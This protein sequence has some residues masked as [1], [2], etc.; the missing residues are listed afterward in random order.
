[1]EEFKIKRYILMSVEG[2]EGEQFKSYA[3]RIDLFSKEKINQSTAVSLSFL[4]ID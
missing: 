1:M 3:K 4:T 2:E